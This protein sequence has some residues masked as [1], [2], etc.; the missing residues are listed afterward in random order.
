MLTTN[1][2]TGDALVS[3]SRGVVVGFERAQAVLEADQL[4]L[5]GLRNSDRVQAAKLE[6]EIAAARRDFMRAPDSVYPIVQFVN[7]VC[8]IIRPTDFEKE[9]YLKGVC[10]RRQ[11]PLKL[12]WAL[13]IHKSQG[14]TL[15]YVIVELDGC[16]DNGQAYVA[17]SRSRSEA[18]LQVLNFRPSIVK[19]SP[20]AVRFAD[21]F[22]AAAEAP[23]LRGREALAA[24]LAS[25]AVPFWLL[26]LLDPTPQRRK[27]R[28]FFETHKYV[29]TWVRKY[30]R[31]ASS[32]HSG[33]RA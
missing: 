16:F 5:K 30:G 27:W 1:L 3:G 10:V 15:D 6:A 18:G 12:A 25:E 13:T 20:L 9:V 31:Q 8:T 4:L 24:F 2:K 21:A 22:S 29:G 14:A 33:G 26:P 17:L 28:S 7:G 19:A 23:A 11:L 32:K